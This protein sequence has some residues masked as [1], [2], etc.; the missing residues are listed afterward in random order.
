M[1]KT[2]TA[3]Q[4]DEIL[5]HESSFCLSCCLTVLVYRPVRLVADGVTLSRR[6][7]RLMSSRAGYVPHSM[8]MP[9]M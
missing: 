4:A 1:S 5:L 7:G 8:L 2:R 6:Q 9:Q 3:L